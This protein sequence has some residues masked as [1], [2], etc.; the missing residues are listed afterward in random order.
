MSY[1]QIDDLNCPNCK[2]ITMGELNI[3]KQ[4]YKCLKCGKIIK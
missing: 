3:K 2:K 1:V 4:E